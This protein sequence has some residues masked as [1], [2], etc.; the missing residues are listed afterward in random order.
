[1][2][3]DT[4]TNRRLRR[5]ILPFPRWRDLPLGIKS[6]AVFAVFTLIMV[7]VIGA[8]TWYGANARAHDLAHTRLN[9]LTLAAR[10]F[11]QDHGQDIEQDLRFLAESR[12]IAEYFA[13]N[14]TPT[15]DDDDQAITHA[16]DLMSAFSDTRD[17]VVRVLLIDRSSGR[18]LVRLHRDSFSGL[19]MTH[20]RPP[21]TL[22]AELK[23]LLSQTP[24]GGGVVSRFVAPPSQDNAAAR[25]SDRPP[26]IVMRFLTHI[27]GGADVP[28]LALVMETGFRHLAFRLTQMQD[29]PG[30]MMVFG[31]DGRLVWQRAG[32]ADAQGH[33]T[34]LSGLFGPVTQAIPAL[35]EGEVPSS[36]SIVH[37]EKLAVLRRVRLHPGSQSAVILAAFNEPGSLLSRL[38]LA[39]DRSVLLSVGFLVLGTAMFLILGS[40][41]VRPLRQTLEE[42]RDYEPGTGAGRLAI[43]LLDRRDEFGE[44]ARDL[45][46]MVLRLEH[47][48][49]RARQLRNDMRR[50]FEASA[51]AKILVSDVGAIEDINR[52]A[53]TL[54]GW[55]PDELL[56]RPAKVLLVPEDADALNLDALEDAPSDPIVSAPDPSRTLTAV[57]REGDHVPVTVAVNDLD[58]AGPYR[59]LVMFHDLRDSQALQNARD[60]NAAKSRFLANMSH[61]LRTP[62][63]AVTLHAEMIADE[64]EDSDNEALKEDSRNI[65]RAANHLLDLINGILDLARIESGRMTLMPEPTDLRGLIEELRTMGT[66]LARKRGNVFNIS[67]KGLPDSVMID[68]LRLRQCLINLM[69]NAAKFTEKGTITLT[70]RGD[71]SELLFSV[72]DTGIGMSEEE[73][74]RIFEIFE[75]ASGYIRAQHGGSGIGLA[76]TRQIVEMMG[77]TVS[78]QSR[79]G[80]GARFDIV[81]PMEQEPATEPGG[82]AGEVAAI[83]LRPGAARKIPLVLV[84]EPDTDRRYEHM[85]SLRRASLAPV[86]AIDLVDAVERARAHRPDLALVAGENT[87]DMIQALRKDLNDNTEAEGVP[88]FGLVSDS[89][90]G[91]AHLV[92]LCGRIRRLTVGTDDWLDGVRA[93]LACEHDDHDGLPGPDDAA[94]HSRPPILVVEDDEDLLWA[95]GSAIERAGLPMVRMNDGAET[96]DWL[97]ANVPCHVLLDLALPGADGFAVVTRM[98]ADPRLA[99]VPIRV[100]TGLDLSADQEAWLSERCESVIRKGNL[101]H[102]ELI[103]SLMTACVGPPGHSCALVEGIG[104]RNAETLKVFMS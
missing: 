98:K 67:V 4:V 23:A 99:R 102:A 16:G 9:G 12:P 5:R 92:G 42:I 46:V 65:V 27:A 13:A 37:D 10:G 80:E 72:S 3:V 73:T 74:T 81:L 97:A 52:A 70:A 18:V 19:M 28:G 68:R 88:V 100:I 75:Q 89:V 45:R 32:E 54:F 11:I 30:G 7:T 71:G 57:L 76:L 29:Q 85:R 103:A 83:V 43:R 56:G 25:L 14:A 8:V 77:G 94:A 61:E 95:L 22:D 39:M 87:A 62:L 79:P 6:A 55:R 82:D 21:D 20:L 60:A 64:A 69:S 2:G 41:L 84:V 104:I 15:R 17:S 33:R 24:D 66:A 50:V 58:Q 44:L 101:D 26:R 31:D 51:D 35:V 63:N 34:D 93:C 78:V 48:I 96:L 90:G 36:L 1:M 49:T 59:Y 91:V 53:Q 47:Q 86:G 40:V 38:G